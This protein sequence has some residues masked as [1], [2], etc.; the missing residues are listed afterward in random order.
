MPDPLSHI[1]ALP[2]AGP[3]NADVSKV[4]GNGSEELKQLLA[5]ALEY[6]AAGGTTVFGSEQAKELVLVEV[7][8][9]KQ[10]AGL[11]TSSLDGTQGVDEAEMIFE[12]EVNEGTNR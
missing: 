3:P 10:R 6:Y 2:T 1:R 4:R 8:L 9:S 7:N 11:R 12:I 5:N